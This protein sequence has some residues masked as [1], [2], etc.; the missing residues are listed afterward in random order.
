MVQTP[1]GLSVVSITPRSMRVAFDKR[2][3]KLVD[4][5]PVVSGRPQHGYVMLEVSPS[6]PQ[7]RVR[8][9]E[10]LLAAL[11]AVRTREVSL[12][13]RSESFA[14]P[15]QLVPPDGIELV[16]GAEVRVQVAISEELVTRKLRDVSVVVKGDGLEPGRWTTTPKVVDVTLT[17]ELLAVENARA[18]LKPVV[19]VPPGE[20]TREADVMIEGLPPGVGVRISPER[21]KVAPAQPNR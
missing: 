3:E 4:V 2:T 9:A 10:S 13:G 20:R 8:G 19:K 14:V 16:D 21:V 11:S 18:A 15:V 17:G 7:V 5:A 6:P 12:Q 1:P